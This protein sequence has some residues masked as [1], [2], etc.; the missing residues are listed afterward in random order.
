LWM[1]MYWYELVHLPGVHPLM[2]IADA[3]SRLKYRPDTDK[4]KTED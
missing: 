3:L 4:D 2:Q 1:S